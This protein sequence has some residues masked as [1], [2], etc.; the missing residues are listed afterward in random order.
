M[1]PG[2]KRGVTRASLISLLSLALAVAPGAS[3][4]PAR[5]SNGQRSAAAQT[6]TATWGS[7][8]QIPEP[9]NALPPEDMANA[10]IRQTIHVSIGG[11]TLRLKLSN[12]FGT[13]A[14][15]IASVDIARP[16]SAGSSKII[17]GSDRTLTFSGAPDVTIP[18]GAEYLSDPVDYP[19]APLSDLTI[20]F[21]EE[22]PPAQETSHPGSRATTYYTHGN[23]V[24]AEDL[25]GAKSIEHWY[26]IAG[27]DVK[28]DSSAS[29]VVTL[30]DSITDGHATTTNGNDRW[31]DVLAQRLQA[32]GKT[33]AVGVVNAG[34]G[35]NRLLAD[36]LG[37]NALARFDRDVLART[38]VRYVMVL[39]GVNDLNGLHGTFPR[40]RPGAPPIGPAGQA[41][42]G[43]PSAGAPTAAPQPAA[44]VQSATASSA[45]PP[46]PPP[47]GAPAAPQPPRFRFPEATPEQHAEL[48][49]QMI[50]AYQ[51]MILRAHA[52]GIKAIGTTITPLGR[53]GDPRPAT[54]EDREKINAWILAPG[55]FDAAVDFSK[56]VADPEDPTRLAPAYDSGDHLHPSPAGYRVMAN[57]IP[58]TLFEAP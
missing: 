58:L 6:W 26:T 29:A 56:A 16:V 54:E 53:P 44:P 27:L 24:S 3:G 33:R 30:G 36:G 20:T 38:G 43:L 32:S 21:Y 18:A 35:G 55:H 57:A 45:Q 47:S 52:A 50:A 37:P 9:R 51:Q 22:K 23:L 11:S 49:H 5:G 31:P 12:A 10:T 25:P 13:A 40:S 15:H 19:I 48:V 14:L 17:P 46:N 41:A 2:M 34:T 8:Q 42:P 4:Q 39:E 28:T 1:V 7:S